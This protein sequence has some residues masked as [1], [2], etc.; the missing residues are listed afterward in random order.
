MVHVGLF[1]IDSAGRRPLLIYGSVACGL[2][3]FLLAVGLAVSS[4]WLS[5]VAMCLYILAF[6]M[7]WAGAFWVLVS[8]LFSMRIK[9]S[10]VSAATATL[11]LSGAV[12]N[13]VFPSMVETLKEYTF[14]IFGMVSL[15]AAVYVYYS[16]PETKG[17]T[18]VEVQACLKR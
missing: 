12:A 4:L 3:M 7:S 6:S 14:V 17:K 11:F 5:V 15:F 10:A 16:V 9:S 13:L 2:A 1:L 18:L 8:E